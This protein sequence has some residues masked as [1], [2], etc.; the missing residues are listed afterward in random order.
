MLIKE[1][2]FGKFVE[3]L[4]RC[5]VEWKVIAIS[6][7]TRSIMKKEASGIYIS[8]VKRL[9]WNALHDYLNRKL[10]S[11]FKTK[12]AE[13]HFISITVKKGVD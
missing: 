1:C 12:M 10:Q 9:A 6:K 3:T 11:R 4:R 13:A 5:F 2:S 8:R 7:R